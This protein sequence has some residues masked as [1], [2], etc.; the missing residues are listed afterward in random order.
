MIP[1]KDE[2]VAFLDSKEDILI[3]HLKERLNVHADDLEKGFIEQHNLEAMLHLIKHALKAPTEN[4]DLNDSIKRIAK[5]MI[6]GKLRES[7]SIED[8]ITSI[9]ILKSEILHQVYHLHTECQDKL[10][11]INKINDVFDQ[12]VLRS[13]SLYME[14]KEKIFKEKNQYINSSHQDRL[15]LLGQMTSS[16]VHEFRNPLTSIHG[17]L[18]LLRAE[19]PELPYLEIMSDEL[20]QLKYRISQFLTLSKK[21]VFESEI[22]I[23]SLEKLIEHVLSFLYPRILEVN[24]EIKKK[25]ANNIFLRGIEDEIRQVLINIIFNA[26][27]ILSKSE[28]PTI[29]IT[30]YEKNNIVSI[31][32]ANNGPPIPE[33]IQEKIFEP[34]ITTKKY[35][36]GLGL[37]VCKE[38]IEKHGG[39]LTCMS[40]ETWTTFTISLPSLK[41][42]LNKT[43]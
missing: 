43:T 30:G 17:F 21:E 29:C 32:I 41:S 38:M 39:K 31:D 18:Q 8:L 22:S 7:K 20:Q 42:K 6:E 25:I 28:K 23:F 14:Q 33:D 3:N 24:V 37:F 15:T 10:P 27:D 11:A 36:T 1:L 13:A 34:F 35:G 5:K 2:I 4:F 26:I 16:F 9:H 40:D 19:H 12:L